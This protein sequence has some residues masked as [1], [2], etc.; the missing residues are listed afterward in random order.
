[1]IARDQSALLVA[2]FDQIRTSFISLVPPIFIS[3][4]IATVQ[5]PPSSNTNADPSHDSPK[6]QKPSTGV[7][8]LPTTNLTQRQL[9]L[10][11]IA[12]I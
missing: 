9:E 10:L 11:P 4:S 8:Y 6:I 7:F 5:P 2:L 3:L 1:M 12:T